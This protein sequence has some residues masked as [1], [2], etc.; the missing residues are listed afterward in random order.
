MKCEVVLSSLRAFR[1]R[2]ATTDVTGSFAFDKIA[3]GDYSLMATCTAHLQTCYLTEDTRPPCSI[4]S[5]VADERRTNADI[6][7][8]PGAIARGRVVDTNGVPVHKAVVRLGMPF[9]DSR[10]LPTRPTATA[11]DGSFE[12]VN[13]PPGEWRVEVDLPEM[14]DVTRLPI[15][16][17]PGVFARDEAAG[18]QLTPG[19][20]TDDVTIVVPPLIENRLIVRITAP[21]EQIGPTDISLMRAA[22]L[23][24]RKLDV[25]ANGIG[26]AKGLMEGTYFVAARALRRSE[27]WV[28]FDIIKFTGE[29]SESSLHLRRAGRIKGRITAERGGLPPLDGL[30]VAAAWVHDGADI[31][32]LVSDEAPVSSD[33]SFDIDGLF[34]SRQIRLIGL[35]SDWAVHSISQGRSDVTA[36]GID[37]PLDTAIG[38]TIVVRRK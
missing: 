34:G 6:W 24:T 21:S 35:H 18:I 32:P 7:V 25:D 29:T 11:A 38:V 22:P 3:D 2:T 17:Y 13:L 37:V 12:L 23:M 1:R 36:S 15:V 5:V 31:N 9:H 19:Q 10:A 26:V 16:Y 20:I 28:A 30:S 14:S 33:G 4:L 8:L 27:P